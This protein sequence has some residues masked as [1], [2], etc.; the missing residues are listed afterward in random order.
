MPGDLDAHQARK[1][2]F[3]N[4]LPVKISGGAARGRA[5]RLPLRNVPGNR[6]AGWDGLA[7]TRVERLSIIVALAGEW[8]GG[9]IVGARCGGCV[10]LPV[11]E[12]G[13]PGNHSMRA[14]YSTSPVLLGAA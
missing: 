11:E 4:G 7:I 9:R 6:S 12:S 10:E 8:S 1:A 14:M 5:A 13:S 3:F 2:I